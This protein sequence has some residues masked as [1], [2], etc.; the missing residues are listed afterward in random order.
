MTV[1]ILDCAGAV[2]FLVV[3]PEAGFHKMIACRASLDAPVVVDRVMSASTVMLVVPAT[4]VSSKEVMAVF[5][6]SPQVPDSSPVT[7]RARPRREVYAVVMC[8]PY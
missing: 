2:M 8:F 3:V 4:A 1:Y 7:G 5:T 6:V